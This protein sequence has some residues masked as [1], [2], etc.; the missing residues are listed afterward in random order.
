MDEAFPI[1]AA[2]VLGLVS[3]TRRLPTWMQS[4]ALVLVAVAAAAISGESERDWQF[5]VFDLAEV[6]A[7]FMIALTIGRA[8]RWRASPKS[9]GWRRSR[10]SGAAKARLE[11]S[12]AGRVRTAACPRQSAR[13]CAPSPA[14]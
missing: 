13:P 2:V 8:Q 10:G 1:I 11:A 5:V 14:C 9:F 12:G 3:A 6:V 7:V 4:A